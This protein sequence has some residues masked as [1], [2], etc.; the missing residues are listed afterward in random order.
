MYKN[1]RS[2]TQYANILDQ[3]EI[4][5][6]E[7]LENIRTDLRTLG[8]AVCTQAPDGQLKGMYFYTECSLQNFDRVP[9]I[10]LSKVNT[11]QRTKMV[12]N[13]YRVYDILDKFSSTSAQC[14]GDII[15]TIQG[16]LTLWKRISQKKFQ[17]TSLCEHCDSWVRDRCRDTAPIMKPKIIRETLKV[18]QVQLRGLVVDSK[19]RCRTHGWN[20]D[21]LNCMDC[22]HAQ[23]CMQ[24]VEC[25]ACRKSSGFVYMQ[26]SS[27]MDAVPEHVD[28]VEETQDS[29][30]ADDDVV[31]DLPTSDEEMDHEHDPGASADGG[32]GYYEESSELNEQ[33]DTRLSVEEDVSLREISL[34]DDDDTLRNWLRTIENTSLRDDPFHCAGPA[35]SC[36]SVEGS[37][38]ELQRQDHAGASNKRRMINEA[39]SPVV[40]RRPRRNYLGELFSRT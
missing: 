5:E 8:N 7:L 35:V 12:G 26:G 31:E 6:E 19:Q 3:H 24:C 23:Y 22:L 28:R 16:R 27:D 36:K 37:S 25:T 9:E 18:K 2:I 39:L 34:D 21:V 13:R 20:F 15:Q 4:D 1:P 32:C 10:F 17:W 14:R 38:A 30:P 11:L 40:P 33:Y 29:D